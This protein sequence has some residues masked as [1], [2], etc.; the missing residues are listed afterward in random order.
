MIELQ[1]GKDKYVYQSAMIA[2]CKEH[3]GH[4]GWVGCKEALDQAAHVQWGVESMFGNTFFYFRDEK[5]ATVFSL[6]FS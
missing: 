4:G 2:W 5:V 6:K 3:A 1:F